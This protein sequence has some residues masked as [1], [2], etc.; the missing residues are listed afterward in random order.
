MTNIIPYIP[1]VSICKQVGVDC[2][3]SFIRQED[4]GS[5]R[6]QGAPGSR[7]ERSMVSGNFFSSSCIA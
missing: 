1:V 3:T 2:G 7:Q 5:G 4:L 6:C